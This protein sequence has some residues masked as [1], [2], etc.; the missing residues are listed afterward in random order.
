MKTGTN[1]RADCMRCLT[2]VVIGLTLAAAPAFSP[3]Q[4]SLTTLVDLAAKNS[5]AVKL[6]EADVQKANAVVSENQNV[7]VPSSTFGSGLPAFPEIGFTGSLPTIWEASLNSM[8]FSMPMI[9]YIQAARAGLQAAQ[10]SLK[11]AREQVTL[12]TSTAYI[13]LDTV[14]EELAA[15]RQQETFANRLVEIEQQRAEAGVDPLSDVLQVR[16]TAAQLKLKRLHLETR[17]STLAKQLSILTGLPVDSI[18]PDHASIPEIPAVRADE[19]P[20]TLPGIKSAQMLERSKERV[21]RG[22]Q[23]RRWY[24]QI[25]FGVQYNRNTTLLNDINAFYEKPLPANN[26]S[27]GFSIQLPVFD[28]GQ[29]AKAR[30]SAADALRAKVEAEQARRQNDLQITTLT[31]SLRELDAQAEIAS[32][33]QQISGEQLKS[34][35]A[36]L[37]LGNGS[38]TGPGATPQL[39]PKAEQ[40]ARIEERQNYEDALAAGLDLSKAR[41]NLLRALGHME[42]W[43]NELHAK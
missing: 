38:G 22:D 24:P 43:L 29:R 35:L 17:A 28:Y 15:V 18:Q 42:D 23:E 33:K 41:L 5:S 25:A 30:E 14:N 32:L 27:S 6:A 31:S 3:A 19:A 12:D 26:F 34:V 21:A 13:E 8:V 16:L 7:F 39:T 20:R 2:G 37:E 11:D 1:P 4:V 9:R 40:Q 36:Q 10:L